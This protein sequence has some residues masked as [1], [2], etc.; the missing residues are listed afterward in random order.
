MTTQHETVG[1]GRQSVRRFGVATLALTLGLGGLVVLAPVTVSTVSA[2]AI[3]VDS[4]GDEPDTNPGDGQCRTAFLTCTLR[5]AIMESNAVVTSDDITFNLDGTG[6]HTIVPATPLPAITSPVVIDGYSQLESV[7][8]TDTVG[9]NADIRVQLSGALVPT[10]A[11]LTVAPFSDGTVVRGLAISGFDAGVLLQSSSIVTGSRFTGNTVGV[12]VSGATGSRVGGSV[13]A[14][15]NQFS[16]NASAGIEVV[17]GSVGTT[18]AGN[19]IGTDAT[20]LVSAAN[21]FGIVVGTGSTFTRIGGT[22]AGERN[23]ISG[24]V[25]SGIYAFS[26]NSDAADVTDTS[27]LGNYIGI[28]A[29]GAAALTNGWYGVELRGNGAREVRRTRV[30]D[31]TPGGRNVISGNTKEGVSIWENTSDT[32]VRGNYIGTAADGATLLG[33]GTLVPDTGGVVV[34]NFASGNKIG[35]ALAGEGNVIAGNRVGVLLFS[36]ERNSVQ[37]NSISDNSQGGIVL[38]GSGVLDRGDADTA[39]ANREINTPRLEVQVDATDVWATARTDSF[40]PN[41]TFPIAVDIYKSVGGQGAQFVGRIGLAKPDTPVR[42]NLGTRAALG[43]DPGSLL[44]ANATDLFGNSSAFSVETVTGRI[45]TVDST[46]VQNDVTPFDGQCRTSVN[47]CTLVAAIQ[48]ANGEAGHDAIHF[49]I[50]G[51]GPHTIDFAVGMPPITS[52][53]TIDGFTQ[54]GASP[55]TQTFGSDASVQIE[56]TG[57]GSGLGFYLPGSAASGSVIRG[58]AINRFDFPVYVDAVAGIARDVV[59]EG[60]YIGAEPDG[61]YLAGNRMSAGV[62]AFAAERLVVG[63]STPANR[64]V[65][66]GT[67]CPSCS[68][69][70][71]TGSAYV[72]GNSIGVDATGSTA[73]GT[74]VG[75]KSTAF[76]QLVIRD[77]LISGHTVGI[78]ATPNLPTSTLQVMGNL[79]GTD[80]SGTA[81]LGNSTGVLVRNAIGASVQV[82][83]GTDAGRNVIGGGSVAVR[84]GQFVLRGNSIGVSEDGLSFL[85]S[86][87]GVL[88]ELNDGSVIGGT[89]P[90]DGNIIAYN[91]VNVDVLSNRNQIVGNRI[92]GAEVIEISLDPASSDPLPNDFEDADSGPNNLQNSPEVTATIIGGT[93]VISAY[94]DADPAFSAYPIQMDYYEVSEFGSGG[95]RYLGRFVL[96]APGLHE[97]VVGSAAGIGVNDGD[98]ITATATDANGNTSEF[99]TNALVESSSALT[100]INPDPGADWS[101]PN[102][103]DGARVPGPFDTAVI[104][105]GFDVLLTQEALVGRLVLQGDLSTSEGLPITFEIIG[106]GTPSLIAA[107]GHLNITADGRVA[108]TGNLTVN[109][110]MTVAATG[111][112]AAADGDIT[113]GGSGDVTL[114]GRLGNEGSGTFL[115]LDDT[116]SWDVRLGARIEAAGNDIEIYTPNWFEGGATYVMGAGGVIFLDGDLTLVTDSTIEIGITGPPTTRN[117]YGTL[118]V[119]GTL[120]R[121]GQLLVDWPALTPTVPG[122]VYDAVY[123]GFCLAG[124][125]NLITS[126]PLEVVSTNDQLLLQ[127]VPNKTLGGP[128]NGNWFGTSVDIDGDWAVVGR[129]NGSF[130]SSPTSQSVSIY[131]FDLATSTWVFQQQLDGPVGFA[132]GEDVA[133]DGNLMAIT[134]RGPGGDDDTT[135]V[136]SRTAPFQPW[137]KFSGEISGAGAVDID[138]T[139]IA[140]G[141]PENAIPTAWVYKAQG[142]FLNLQQVLWPHGNNAPL[143][144]D[145]YGASISIWYD[146]AN[147][148]GAVAVGAPRTSAPGQVYVFERGNAP[149]WNADPTDIFTSPDGAAVNDQFANSV[150]ISPNTLAVGQPLY[151]TPQLHQGA[152]WTY[153]GAPNAFAAAQRFRA[154]NAEAA[155][156]FGYSVALDGA[157]MVVGAPAAQKFNVAMRDGAAYVFERGAGNVWNETRILRADDGEDGERFG[158]AV[159]VDGANTLIGAPLDSDQFGP[160]AGAVY[161]FDVAVPPTLDFGLAVSAGSPTDVEVAPSGLAVTLFDRALFEQRSTSTVA[162]SSIS[163]I[164]VEDT[165]IASIAIG[166]TPLRSIV[167]DSAPLRSI[168][169]RSIDVTTEQGDGWPALLA[170]TDFETQSITDLTFGDVLADPI[171]GARIQALPLRSID[172]AGTPLRSISLAA[173]ALGSTPLR[174]IPLRSIAPGEP[175]PW[176]AIIADLLVASNETCEQALDHLNVMEVTLRGVSLSTI[177]LRSIPLR[178]IDLAESPLRSIPLRSIDL[179][180]SPLRSIP[181]RSIPLR[182]IG[183]LVS[184]LRSIPLRSIPLRSIPLRSIDLDAI[185]VS[186]TPLRSIDVNGTPLRSIDVDGT[187]LRSIPLRSI[188]LEQSPLRSIPLRSIPLRSIPLRSI[189]LEQSPL[190]SIPLRSIDVQGSALS[191]V[192]LRSIAVGVLPLRSIPLRSIPLRSIPLRSIPLRSIDVN[193]TPLRSIP[194]RSIDVIGSPLRSIPLRSIQALGVQIDCAKADCS[195][196]TLFDAVTAGAISPDTRLEQLL[197]ATTGVSLGELAP[198]IQGFGIEQMLAS[199]DATF[200]LEDLTG[201]D[202]L[203]LGDLPMSIDELSSLTLGQLSA[204]LADV[205]YADLVGAATNPATGQLFTFA[206]LQALADATSATVGQL[207]DYGDLTMGDLLDVAGP[208]TLTALGSLLDLISVEEL[209]SIVGPVIGQQIAANITLGDLTAEQIG[210]MTLLDVAAAIGDAT[211]GDLLAELDH[212]GLLE[213]LTLGDLLL[214]MLDPSSLAQSGAEFQ[215]LA[216]DELPAGAV[217]STSFTASFR[218]GGSRARNVVLEI[219]LPSAS[220]YVPGTATFDGTALEP[221]IVG[222]SAQWTVTVEPD[223]DHEIAFEVLPTLRLGATSLAGTASVVGTDIVVPASATVTV[224]EGIEPNDFR[225]VGPQP[226]ARE[227]TRA[228]EDTVYLTYVSS[229]TDI[230]VFEIDIAENDELIANLSNLDADLD[231]YLWRRVGPSTGG[232]ALSGTSGQQPLFPITDPDAAGAS[233]TPLADFP[234]LDTIDP[235]VEL[236]ATS[237]RVGTR[238]EN[239]ATDRLPAGTYFVQVVGANGVTNTQPAALQLKVNEAQARPAC[240]AIAPL[241]ARQSVPAAA[242]IPSDANTLILVNPSRL[243]QLYGAAGRIEVNDALAALAGYLGSP[244]GAALELRPVVVSVDSYQAVRDAYDHWDSAAGSCDPDAANAVV[245]AINQQIID[246][247]RAQFDH[248]VVLGGDTVIPMARLLDS[249]VAAN[250]YTYR[251]ELEG[252]LVGGALRNA[253]NASHWEGMILSDEPYGEESARSLGNRYLYVS[254]AA[255]GRVVESPTEIADALRTFIDFNGT[256][257]IDTAA[258]LGYDFLSDGSAAVADALTDGGIANVDRELA[259]GVDANGN[260]WDRVAAENKINNLQ[261]NALVSLNAHFDHYRALPA[262][263]DKVP[264]FD[265]NLVAAELAPGAS[266]VQ[267]LVFSMGCHS[268]FS[269]SDIL[270][271]ATNADWAQE[272]GRDGALFVGNTGFGYGDTEAVAYTELLM[273]YFAG[274]V[275]AP[276]ELP[277]LGGEAPSTVGQALMWAKNDFYAATESNFSVYD[278]KAL[279]EST[280]Y[281][282]PFYRVGLPA[283]PLPTTPTRR[284]VPDESGTPTTRVVVATSN[285]AVVTDSG[286]YY[287]NTDTG[288]EQVIVAPGR[289]V[290]PKATR[291]ISVVS[292]NDPTQLELE[293]RGAIVLGMTSTYVSLTDPYVASPVFDEASGVPEPDAGDGAFPTKIA[294]IATSTNPEGQRQQLVLATGQYRGDSAVQRLDDDIDVVVY[295]ADPANPDRVLPTIAKVDSAAS[296]GRLA[297]TVTA[298]DLGSGVDRVYVLVAQN[299]GRAGSTWTGLDLVRV[300]GTDRWSGSLVLAP[301]TTDVEFLVQVK[302]LAGNVGVSTNK[303][304]NFADDLQPAPAPVVAPTAAL[305]VTVPPATNGS[306]AGPVT[307]SVTSQTPVVV[308]IDGTAR[309][310]P[311]GPST[312]LIEGDGTHHWSAA[313]QSG[314][315]TSGL[316]VIDTSAPTVSVDRVPGPVTLPTVVRL[317]AADA[318]T[319]VN[320]IEYSVSGAQTQAT[321]VAQGNSALVTLSAQGITTIT[322]RSFDLAGN[323]SPERTFTYDVNGT[324][325]VV[326]GTLSTQPNAA[327]WLNTPVLVTWSV[328]DPLANVPAPTPVRLQ[329]A[330][331]RIV[332][333]ESCDTA[334]N[335]ATGSVTLKLDFAAPVATAVTTP[336]ANEFDWNNTPVTVSVVCA[337]DLSGVTCPAPTTITT[338]VTGLTV[339]I[340]V[341]D[342][343]GNVSGIVSRT[344]NID[345]IA[346]VI[347]WNAPADGTVVNE[348]AY[349]RPTC[350]ATDERSGVNGICSVEIT[351]PVMTPGYAQY[352]ASVSISDRAGNVATK[353]STYRV[354][355]DSAGPIVSVTSDPEANAA[356][357]WRTPV[358][359]T[360]ACV[361]PSGVAACPAPRTVSTQGANQTFEVTA[362]DVL[363]NATPLNV[364]GINIDTVAPVVTVTAPLTVGPLDTVVIT[365]SATDALSGIATADCTDRTFPASQLV[366]GANTLTFSATDRAGNTTTVTKTVTLVIP[367]NPAPTVRADM[368]VSGLQEIGFQSSIV[369]INGTFADPNGPGPYSAS[370]RWQAGGPF[371]PLILAGDGR[372]VAAWI[373]GGA[374]VRTVT[375]RICDAQGACGT[376]DLTVRTNVTQKITPVRECIVDRGATSNP[377]Y[378]ARWGYNNPAAFAIAVPSIPLLENTFTSAPFLRGQP[379]IFLPGNRRG[380]F[381]TPFASGSLGWRVNGVTATA[382]SSNAKC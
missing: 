55:N 241:P 190:R 65:F 366:A 68:M 41:V 305:N 204:A 24:N 144:I 276:L 66:V 127:D 361:D 87:V 141:D 357:W 97:F 374:G 370:V 311:A 211:L 193:G 380:V 382:S 122:D 376:D 36:G 379:Q 51:A 360:F 291:D 5:A 202:E 331:V 234:R 238:T 318:G 250:E 201:L 271:G 185:S 16:S 8:N 148:D 92:L 136:Y 183:L 39:G 172:V 108:L 265:D 216:A 298:T 130:A 60:N 98:L 339:P 353:T 147:D 262:I 166:S 253:A 362:T 231:L 213:G 175:N 17:N 18:V 358:T 78:S 38:T 269:A 85:S 304:T 289:P 219:E 324:P 251:N 342:N 359:F 319:G 306:Y 116:V 63:G 176:C 99:A 309:T 119:T 84:G 293:A 154:S 308:T 284:T 33:N 125:W 102:N 208:V 228:A 347:T 207:A 255:L 214:A 140:V 178:S 40:A 217:G 367:V 198:F 174:S 109:G 215:R 96:P 105:A 243:Q 88:L 115:T 222:S 264:G 315:T 10:S 143:F 23:V 2:A 335:C 350:T 9:I 6:P 71:I 235:S 345:R 34:R 200:T 133:I 244:E 263:G 221:T 307:V 49:A 1:T 281:G 285:E 3:V 322:A 113:I 326:T 72:E 110:S 242:T 260:K 373:Y 354:R 273:A 101:E 53:I 181:L 348:A 278:E 346:P 337:P 240:Q 295:Y 323:A 114:F 218:L 46:G 118:D 153:A 177:P 128:S 334:G 13:A 266:L 286:T 182:S 233:A 349:V 292:P 280:F 209:E 268:G 124:S 377:R 164:G 225:F 131:H 272:M 258:V 112:L 93:L 146:V 330:G 363:G 328:D 83:D 76:D 7:P 14:E 336:D 224:S 69:V 62:Q 320:R 170:G 355:T 28:D 275:T 111:D 229:P 162:A 329:S 203:T 20:G 120:T 35:G 179:A 121:R 372:F 145:N 58:L 316:V 310:L 117:N 321:T 160:D 159:A 312:F 94:I 126:Q 22:N 123:C 156:Q 196:G 82:G 230:D 187:P 356:G 184:P 303:A 270:I 70:D 151:S 107:T 365:C 152:V 332:S 364:S 74:D 137:V 283:D 340:S 351:E 161:S 333:G 12:R 226:T 195:F 165:A 301:T 139:S 313:A 220:S 344:I 192:P 279:Q 257:S 288:T 142:P 79:I 100:F 186:G 29:T 199:I 317:S 64:N 341:V 343:A 169:L 375:V 189:E 167:L 227:T 325:P 19:L 173:I 245:A 180:E 352:T 236:V 168:P 61:T 4:T 59:V 26:T 48:Q 95:D 25:Y 378:E 287:A 300:P 191:T 188:D 67:N 237:N 239:I 149:T 90:F 42:V 57:P 302:D 232:G 247:H 11:G 155:D 277:S 206:E 249:A 299:P 205:T 246:P 194:L 129:S 47:T 81:V 138:N 104:P 134:K 368:G 54:A 210:K 50:A 89:G 163:E 75:V 327:G 27:V 157:T 338:D 31:A 369:I 381:S 52:S 197:P 158:D 73:N 252:K 37:G 212:A 256:L 267:S 15:R 132:Y 274:R 294:S 248:I 80:A 91:S 296:N 297:I 45:L 259:D 314:H 223:V 254:D 282:L 261:G 86:G 371:T 44:V 171:V 56:L 77:N 290:Q 150:A 43:I 32:A 30:G 103:W 106:T 21:A 135:E